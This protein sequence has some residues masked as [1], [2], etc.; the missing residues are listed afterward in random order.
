MIPPEIIKNA[1]WMRI[2]QEK[3]ALLFPFYL[4]ARVL[5][6]DI[7]EIIGINLSPILVY[8]GPK[9]MEY[10][11]DRQNMAEVGKLAY[12]TNFNSEKYEKTLVY[13]DEGIDRLINLYQ[14]IDNLKNNL[15]PNQIKNYIALLAEEICFVNKWNQYSTLSEY[16]ENNFISGALGEKVGSKLN[17]KKVQLS[18]VRT[19][20]LLLSPTRETIM[21]REIINLMRIA[22]K[23]KTF[24]K[25][26]EA[27][28][29]KAEIKMHQKLFCWL[30]FGY[31]GPVHDFAY[32]YDR[33]KQL[34]QDENLAEKYLDRK[35]EMKELF[36][37]QQEYEEFLELS[38]EDKHKFFLAR[39]LGYYKVY[40]KEITY[41]GMY[42]L[43]E[44]TKILAERWN[45][46]H[47]YFFYVL[48][49]E[50][51]SALKIS[52]LAQERSQECIYLTHEGQE[53]IITGA[54]VELIM[55]SVRKSYLPTQ[56]TNQKVFQG[57]ATFVIKDK[58]KGRAKIVNGSNH[59]HKVN[60]GDILISFA[61]NPQMVVVM[62]K[63]AAIVTEQ[64]GITCHAAI[65]SREMKKPCLVG[66]T[67]ITQIIKDNDLVEVDTTNGH[68]TV[69]DE[70][71]CK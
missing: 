55:K 9:S 45:I 58:I 4:F 28:E 10:F 41:M 39:D 40:R 48:P 11:V 37:K 7:K 63:A 32:Y 15:T 52:S 21:H 33:I 23:A 14:K 5:A 61:T 67:G 46:D 26:L 2:V 71:E 29:I 31:I 3:D 24:E 36:L 35:I 6:R 18:L 16:G 64:G 65:V 59:L 69:L 44:L 20:S 56:L 22:L 57:S 54:R 50:Y 25:G 12:E 68:L 17:E 30:D 19:M 8:F 62:D 1:Q 53:E 66:V 51:E 38:A 49:E 27:E 60:R 43:N 70:E 13:L 47:S 34:S 42:M